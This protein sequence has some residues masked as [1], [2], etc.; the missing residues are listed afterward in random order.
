MISLSDFL[1]TGENSKVKDIH[2]NQF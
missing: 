2:E 1:I